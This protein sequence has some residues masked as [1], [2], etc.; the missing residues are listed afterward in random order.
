MSCDMELPKYRCHKEVWALKIKSI[1]YDGEGENRESNGTAMIIPVEE[2]Y[3]PFSVNS[4]WLLR[5]PKVAVGGYFVVYKR[6]HG[7]THNYTA[8]S[9]A[10]AFEDG[11]TR[12]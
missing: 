1:K 7:E 11:Y 4:E 3:A 8:Y 10:E 9:P 6:M 2:S 5:N 12:I